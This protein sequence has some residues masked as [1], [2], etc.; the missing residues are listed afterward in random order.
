MRGQRI[1]R[2]TVL[3]ALTLALVSARSVRSQTR[4]SPSRLEM[5]AKE[6]VPTQDIIYVVGAVAKPGGFVLKEP[7]ITV[8][9]ALALA[10]GLTYKANPRAARIVRRRADGSQEEVRVDLEEKR[11]LEQ[12]P[13]FAGD[14]LFVPPKASAQPLRGRPGPGCCWDDHWPFHLWALQDQ[15]AGSS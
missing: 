10:D 13:M 7:Q 12:T 4:G 2:V 3:A 5:Q 11:I 1:S 14:V 8:Q 9:T 6:S 15:A